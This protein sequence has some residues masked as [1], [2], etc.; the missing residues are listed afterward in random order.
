MPARVVVVLEDPVLSGA[1]VAALQE[2][3][4]D[5]I[6]IPDSMDALDALESAAR[7]E[8]LVTSAEFRP[9][10]PNGVALA[11]LTKLKRPD[12]KVVFMGT[13]DFARFIEG[14]GLFIPVPVT[15]HEISQSVF[16]LLEPDQKNSG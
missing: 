11:R 12:V 3:G 10:K 4:Y 6:A 2:R 5:A 14:V 15:A 16:E 7:I 13:A 1:T 8:V 9:G